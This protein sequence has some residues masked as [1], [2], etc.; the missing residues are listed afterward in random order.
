MWFNLAEGWAVNW[1]SSAF[2]PDSMMGWLITLCL[3]SLWLVSWHRRQ[4]AA[5]KPGMA[6]WYFIIP[7]F[8]VAALA[9]AA[10]AYGLGLQGRSEAKAEAPVV[11]T[12]LQLG[13]AA[14]EKAKPKFVI[15]EQIGASYSANPSPQQPSN[16]K[17]PSRQT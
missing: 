9:I 14:P 6:S 15:N 17:E 16:I 13:P 3:V 7:C 2:G 4:R 10:G 11:A 1:L 5:K 12:H 8:V